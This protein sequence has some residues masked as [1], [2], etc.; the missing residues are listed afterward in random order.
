MEKAGSNGKQHPLQATTSTIVGVIT[1]G[2]GQLSHDTHR[3]FNA[4]TIIIII[5]LLIWE[6]I[7][8]AATTP[9]LAAVQEEEEAKKKKTTT[10]TMFT[11]SRCM[12]KLG[13]G[14]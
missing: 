1:R 13:K 2:G 6:A 14:G 10:T 3:A 4:L 9:E 11:S 7:A 12:R 8:A 5:P